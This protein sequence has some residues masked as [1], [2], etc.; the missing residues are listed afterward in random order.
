MHIVW[1]SDEVQSAAY[2]VRA[3]TVLMCFEIDHIFQK[4]KF[5]SIFEVTSES[6]NIHLRP[7][8]MYI[9]MFSKFSA[10]IDRLIRYN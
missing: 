1:S 8:I 10:R 7:I 9:Q 5:Q 6:L 4:K 2:G 3:G